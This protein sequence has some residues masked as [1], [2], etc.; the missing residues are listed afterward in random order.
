MRP[1]FAA[2][3]QSLCHAGARF[4]AQRLAICNAPRPDAPTNTFRFDPRAAAILSRRPPDLVTLPRRGAF[5]LGDTHDRP[6]PGTPRRDTIAVTRPEPDLFATALR[7]HQAGRLDQAEGLYNRIL[8][9]DPRHAESLHLLGVVACQ[10]GQHDT[11]IDLIRRAI[12]L[13]GD[14]ATYHA[15]LAIALRDHGEIDAAIA[16]YQCALALI[17]DDAELHD[18]LGGM[19]HAQ[20]RLTEALMH[21]RQAS[22]LRPDDARLHYNLGLV[23]H[24]QGDRAASV[25][26]YRRAL[27]RAP[28][29]A[30]IHYNLGIALYE[31]GRHADSIA[32][33][34][35]AIALRPDD[36]A[37]HYNLAAVL[38]A[39]G[40][41]AEAAGHYERTLALYP[42][43]AGAHNRLGNVLCE[44][45]RPTKAIPHYQRARALRPDDADILANLGKAYRDQGDLAA[46]RKEFQSAI[47]LAPRRGR[48]YGALVSLMHVTSGDGVLAAMQM[49][50]QDITSLPRDDQIELRFALAKAH[51]DLEQ[52]ALAFDHLHAG[53]ALKRRTIAYDEKAALAQFDRVRTVF[54][55]A[56]LR[57]R[58]AWGDPS[59]RPI[60][61]VGMP[62]S[63]TTLVEQILASHPAVFGAGERSELPRGVAN[64][65]APNI[66]LGFPEI[67]PGLSDTR[68]R[69]F[70]REYLDAI[71]PSAPTA[72]RITDKMPSNFW[73]AGLIHLALPGARIIHVRRDPLDTCLSCFSLLFTGDHPY[74]YD[75]GELGRY[76]RAYAALMAHWRQVLPPDAMFEVAYEDLVADLVP[77]VRRIV[78][79]C[80]LD[81]DDACLDFMATQRPV[82]NA[83]APQVRQ[84]IYRSS[85]GRWRPYAAFLQPLIEALGVDTPT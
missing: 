11:A 72:T 60:F 6:H 73:F 16:Q 14:V 50:A 1:A 49:L 65:R 30:D 36:A 42:D 62:R 83:S 8:A 55:P 51:M 52:P 67:V 34:Q 26:E 69:A 37:T 46:A 33:Y 48:Y 24:D 2:S 80:G 54:T 77:Q 17:P 68:L 9:E 38:E 4:S 47:D 61:I 59:D 7:H 32:S 18:A 58:Q 85:V 75:L 23:L 76:Y 27:A 63:G 3:P 44:Q 19:L 43:H 29:D 25:T 13:R 45:G 64:L 82:R 56:L 74:A 28:E 31:L 81:W 10:R 71:L 79:Y 12:A 53:N 20:G 84:P 70:G 66:N 21:Y 5:A 22:A 15:N 57:D 78:A 40:R 35:Q 39:L 41:P